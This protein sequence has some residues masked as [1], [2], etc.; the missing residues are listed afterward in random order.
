MGK[1]LV[2]IG[3]FDIIECPD[4][5]SKDIDKYRRLFDDFLENGNHNLLLI[6]ERTGEKSLCYTTEDFLDWLNEKVINDTEER[7][8]LLKS[9][10]KPS[11]KDCELPH[12][13]F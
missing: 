13:Y 3:W 1:I 5:I 8:K 2:E 10:V 6:D 7:C 4:R 12:I 9:D 11:K